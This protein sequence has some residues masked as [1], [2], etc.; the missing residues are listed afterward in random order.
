M[1]AVNLS[2]L[3]E[4][5]FYDGQLAHCAKH[6]DIPGMTD[7]LASG[8]CPTGLFNV[9]HYDPDYV[10]DVLDATVPLSPEARDEAQE[11]LGAM[12]NRLNK[13]QGDIY[14]AWMA[15]QAAMEALRA[16]MAL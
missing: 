4:E 8:S 13:N 14:R 1:A 7:L 15:K 2:Q 3:I 11:I 16:I 6:R 9:L 10:L 5:N 12:C